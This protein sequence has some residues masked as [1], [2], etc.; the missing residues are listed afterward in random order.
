[1]NI[2]KTA[3]DFKK[4][5]LNLDEKALAL[6]LLEYE[7]AFRKLSSEAEKIIESIIADGVLPTYSQLLRLKRI[8]ALIKQINA[9]MN[10]YK[11]NVAFII[12][13]TQNQ[14]VNIGMAQAEALITSMGSSKF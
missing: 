8:Q 2:E 5:M 1:M 4:R 12:E 10:N 14:A 11:K 3:R 13:A 6:I 9:E 7:K